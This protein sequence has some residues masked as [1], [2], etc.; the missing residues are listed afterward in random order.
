MFLS[1]VRMVC[2]PEEHIYIYPEIINKRGMR[3]RKAPL[4]RK[5]SIK[6]VNVRG[7]LTTL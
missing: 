4:A 6:A 3:K 5:Y 2:Y 7:S 1:V